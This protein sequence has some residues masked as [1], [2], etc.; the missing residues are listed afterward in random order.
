VLRLHAT[1]TNAAFMGHLRQQMT[2]QPTGLLLPNILRMTTMF[3]ATDQRDKLYG[4]LSL[5]TEGARL[6]HLLRVRLA[7][8]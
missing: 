6:S 4:V 8:N 5:T 2:L 1:L 3:E 7:R